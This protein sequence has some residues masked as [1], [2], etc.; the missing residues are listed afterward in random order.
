MIVPSDCAVLLLPALL[1]SRLNVALLSV[2]GTPVPLRLLLMRL[3]G[4][5][6]LPPPAAV[7]LSRFSV[8]FWLT[9]KLA[10]A[11]R[12]AEA[13]Q[14]QCA[15]SERAALLVPLTAPLMVVARL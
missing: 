6:T 2:T 7:L 14:R 11:Q 5:A 12:R 1:A 3:S 9:V 10:A 15:G 13:V 4:N 8:L